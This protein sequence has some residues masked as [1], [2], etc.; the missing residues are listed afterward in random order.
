MDFNS[1]TVGSAFYLLQKAETPTLKI[2]KVKAKT[3]PQPKYSTPGAYNNIQNVI[4]ITADFD[5]KTET[6]SDIP[7]NLQIAA[8]GNDT[9]SG[10]REVML[11]AV[12]DMINES[13]KSL[14]MIDYHKSVLQEGEKMLEVLNPRYAEEKKQA[15][16]IKELETR[17]AATDAKLDNILALLKDMQPSSSCKNSK[18]SE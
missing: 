10:N 18:K 11:Q 13:K 9:F 4:T 1:L 7:Y 15:R 5:G 8:R 16:T 17:Q 12:N 6:F 3:P 2:G 14:Q